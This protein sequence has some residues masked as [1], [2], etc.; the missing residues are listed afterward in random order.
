[1]T[2]LGQEW[3]YFDWIMTN[4]GQER[5]CFYRIKHFVGRDSAIS[6]GR[7]TILGQKRVFVDWR[8]TNLG[9]KRVCDE[10]R[11]TNFG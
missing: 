10:R 11:I 2:F 1:M 6:S 9:R 7:M 3:L 5:V 8:I 4:L